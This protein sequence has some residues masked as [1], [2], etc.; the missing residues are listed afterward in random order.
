MAVVSDRTI[1]LARHFFDGL[2]HPKVVELLD[3]SNAI[4][5]SLNQV[6]VL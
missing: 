4:I 6:L 3:F 2:N 5:G 1:L